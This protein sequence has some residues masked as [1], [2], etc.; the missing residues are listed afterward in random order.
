MELTRVVINPRKF[1]G[2]HEEL[3]ELR[4]YAKQ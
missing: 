2:K 1:D 4:L 3:V